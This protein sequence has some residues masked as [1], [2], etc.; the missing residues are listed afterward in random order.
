MPALI[1]GLSG[2]E[3]ENRHPYSTTSGRSYGESTGNK[4]RGG[5]KGAMAMGSS[6][7]QG[8]G[9]ERGSRRRSELRCHQHYT[10]VLQ[11]KESGESRA[12]GKGRWWQFDIRCVRIC[13]S[14]HLIWSGPRTKTTARIN[15]LF[16]YIRTTRVAGKLFLFWPFH[17]S[18]DRGEF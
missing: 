17:R 10:R 4:A 5:R 11:W 13:H 1:R 2:R 12:R 6:T 7:G 14:A 9:V 18:S 15:P 3:R 16:Y 8:D